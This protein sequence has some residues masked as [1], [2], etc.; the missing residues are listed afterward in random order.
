MRT[1]AEEEAW[2]EEE[3]W[4]EVVRVMYGLFAFRN[5][6]VIVVDNLRLFSRLVFKLFSLLLQRFG[7]ISSKN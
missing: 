4:A 1:W 5:C 2:E 3:V 6:Q 7:H